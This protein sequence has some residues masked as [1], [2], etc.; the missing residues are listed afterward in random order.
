MKGL[1]VDVIPNS[2]NP[3]NHTSPVFDSRLKSMKIYHSL[4]LAIPQ[5][6]LGK[7]ITVIN[8]LVF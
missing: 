1:H 7:R 6:P 8:P 2:A 5:N 4:R 3:T